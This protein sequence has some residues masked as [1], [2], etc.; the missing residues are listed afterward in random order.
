VTVV[1]VIMIAVIVIFETTISAMMIFAT[2]LAVSQL[3][4]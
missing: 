1:A 3:R 2:F 4:A